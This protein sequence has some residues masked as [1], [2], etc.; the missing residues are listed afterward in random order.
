M[1]IYMKI[2]VRKP[3]SIFSSF[4]L[5]FFVVVTSFL[6]NVFLSLSF[7]W[8]GGCWSDLYMCVVSLYCTHIFVCTHAQSHVPLRPESDI[9][10]FSLSPSTQSQQTGSSTRSR[11]EQNC[12]NHLEIFL[13]YL[14]TIQ[15]LQAQ[16]DQIFTQDLGTILNHKTHYLVS[17]EKEV[18]IQQKE[19]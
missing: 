8:F 9:G 2:Y 13:F 4:H 19:P 16:T 12:Q 1:H 5:L 18:Q 15:E 7:M 10:C 14:T 11:A 3:R 6:F 17:Q